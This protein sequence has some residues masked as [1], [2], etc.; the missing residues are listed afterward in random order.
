[1]PSKIVSIRSSFITSTK[2]LHLFQF[3]IYCFRFSCS[4][5]CCKKHKEDDKNCVSEESKVT[6]T[7]DTVEK[8]QPNYVT[9]DT[10]PQNVL[11]QLCK[12]FNSSSEPTV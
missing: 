7:T 10:V 6:E 8:Q 9:E 5:P 12:Y 11:Q 1:M 2:S 3:K 4:V